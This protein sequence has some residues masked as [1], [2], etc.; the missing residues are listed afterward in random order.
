MKG[1]ILLLLCVAVLLFAACGQAGSTDYEWLPK[2]ANDKEI[3]LFNRFTQQMLTFDTNSCSVVSVNDTDN[4]VQYE[5]TD[6]PFCP[7]FTSGHSYENHFKIIESVDGQ[8]R[9]LYEMEDDE[10]IFPLAYKNE[11]EFFWSNTCMTKKG[12]KSVKKG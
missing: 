12:M 9:T 10:A 8:A 1:N 2:A 5:F 6:N 7:V 11:N 3:L 4:F